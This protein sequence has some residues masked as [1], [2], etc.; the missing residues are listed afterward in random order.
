MA[1]R[2]EELALCKRRLRKEKGRFHFVSGSKKSSKKY[3]V[4]ATAIFLAAGVTIGAVIDSITKALKATGKSL[5]NGL[6]ELGKKKKTASLLPELLGSIV[7]IFSFQ[8]CW[9]GHRFSG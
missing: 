9:S 6:K 2:N 1:E 5:G 8:S 3:R 4:T 7:L